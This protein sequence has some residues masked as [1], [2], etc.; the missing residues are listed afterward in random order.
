MKTKFI[1][2]SLLLAL[3]FSAQATLYTYSG[4][5]AVIPDNNTIGLAESLSVS[6]LNVSISA[7]TLI[8]TLAGGSGTDL[9]GYLRLGNLSGS[10]SYS[11]TSLVQADP[12]ISSSG[13]LF[14]VD[15][16]SFFSGYN[17]NDTWTLFFADTV[18]GDTTTLNGG[19]SLDITAVPEPVNVALA[20]FGVALLGTGVARWRSSSTPA[21]SRT[22]TTDISIHG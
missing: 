2:I 18:S 4:G 1:T 16:S 5:D 13:V 11:L 7:A 3:N 8:F 10:P 21:A 15:V 12:T 17:P 19:W 22:R 20:I 9:A 6:G 14:T